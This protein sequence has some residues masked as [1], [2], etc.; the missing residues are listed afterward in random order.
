M[1][2]FKVDDGFANSKPVLRI[3]RRYRAPAIG[4]WVLAGTWSA[5]E[6]TDGFVPDYALE[7]FASTPA[8]AEQLVRAGLWEKAENG[9]QFV[10]WSNYQP[11]KVQVLTRRAEEADR[12]SRAREAKRKRADLQVVDN[13][14]NVSQWDTHG[15]PQDVR[16]ESALPDPTRPDPTPSRGI[17]G[18]EVTLVGARCPRHQLDPDPPPCGACASARRANDAA[19]Q[20]ADAQR[21]RFNAANRAA[22]DSCDQ[23]DDR[24]LIDLDDDRGLIRCSHDAMVAHA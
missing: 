12:K 23:C 5:K 11:T 8:M 14:R 4:L 17:L 1:P 21:A 2:W 10:G 19:K 16:P 18:G 24:G 7:D 13:V 3:P 20:T 9:Y 6:L 15:C 22:I